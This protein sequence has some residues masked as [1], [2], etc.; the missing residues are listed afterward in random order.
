[1]ARVARFRNSPRSACGTA[2]LAFH[3]E[4]QAA[5]SHVGGMEGIRLVS[6]Q[7]H[8]LGPVGRST[9]N[10]TPRSAIPF[11]D[12]AV[13]SGGTKRSAGPSPGGAGVGPAQHMLVAR[14][15]IGAAVGSRS[16]P[17]ERSWTARGH[18]SARATQATTVLGGDSSAPHG[19]VADATCTPPT[20]PT[21][22]SGQENH[23]DMEPPVTTASHDDRVTRQCYTS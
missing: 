19:A 16:E 1:M 17:R 22:P 10:T 15:G 11:T 14:R 5:T 3:V 23:C 12:D 20:A 8:P 13:R 21:R 9:W 18:T 4:R 2:L 6:W 7:A